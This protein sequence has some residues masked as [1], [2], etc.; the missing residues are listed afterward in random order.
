LNILE[1]DDDDEDDEALGPGYTRVRKVTSGNPIVSYSADKEE[2]EMF[3]LE[4][5]KATGAR[6]K[7]GAVRRWLQN[8]GNDERSPDEEDVE[9]G[10]NDNDL[11]TV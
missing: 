11:A 4:D 5:E 3:E 9:Y 10:N 6:P 7:N 1:Y 8:R 2:V